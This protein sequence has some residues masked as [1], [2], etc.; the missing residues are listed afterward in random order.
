MK[1]AIF[2]DFYAADTEKW[3]ALNC[4]LCSKA[5]ERDFAKI[6]RLQPDAIVEVISFIIN[7]KID[8]WE[9]NKAYD[10]FE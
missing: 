2:P 5:D 6:L 4:E 7:F 8:D 1:Y 9:L 3:L 10:H